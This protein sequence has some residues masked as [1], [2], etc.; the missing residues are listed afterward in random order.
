[1]HYFAP[2]VT[3][4]LV[5]SPSLSCLSLPEVTESIQRGKGIEGVPSGFRSQMY[6]PHLGSIHTEMLDFKN[7]TLDF[8][9]KTLDLYIPKCER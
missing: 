7:K 5:L 9:N 4:S 1:M 3:V 2:G 8:K 6:S